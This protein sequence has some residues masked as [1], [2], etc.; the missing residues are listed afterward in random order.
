VIILSLILI[1]AANKKKALNALADIERHAKLTIDG[2]PR[3]LDVDEAEDVTRS[4]L[5]QKP[6]SVV[7]L[8]VLVRVQESTTT[9]IMNIKKIHPP[10]HLI[11]ISEEYPVY[12]E[13]NKKFSSLKTFQGYYS[14]KK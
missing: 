5:K 1:R 11:V 13:L 3:L 8:A 4:I 6:K 2:K 10:A 12:E 14:M 9:S 7:N